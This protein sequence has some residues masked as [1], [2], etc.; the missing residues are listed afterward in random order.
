MHIGV[1]GNPESW[2]VA[3]LSR[4][5]AERGHR[6]SRIDYRTLSC[7]VGDQR[8]EVR[9]QRSEV[10]GQKP[11]SGSDAFSRNN[12]QHLPTSDL[13]P[14]ISVSI[15]SG[16]LDLLSLDA[17]VIRTMPP[18]SLEQVVFRMDALHRVAAHGIPVLNPPR[19]IEHAV[20]KYLA[21]AKLAAA[22]L[23]VPETIVCE[24]AETALEAFERLGGDVVVKPV[25]GAEGRG[26][27]RVSDPDIAL[28]VFRTLERID[29]VLYLQR[30]IRH[31]GYDL[32]V[33]VLGGRPIGAMRRYASDGFRTN[34]ACKG[35]GESVI[36]SDDDVRR[37]LLATEVIGATF[38]GVDLLTGPDGEPYVVEV[39][40]VPGWQGFQ[41]ATG[42]D[43]AARLVEW[44]AEAGGRRSEVG[45]QKSEAEPVLHV[46]KNDLRLPTSDR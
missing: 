6:V 35:R 46:S 29:A 38:A 15:T 37:A 11:E 7:G 18:G 45:G 27:V 31:P 2:Y 33:L 9:S 4:A 41:K 16:D 17:V 23:P 34:I 26:I 21:T 19:A 39:N 30:F 25:F 5:A 42:I 44:L 13:R 14:P 10:G 22:G 28:R 12:V 24:S 36:P 1:L 40:G 20:D 8:Q 32:R 43:V 3:D